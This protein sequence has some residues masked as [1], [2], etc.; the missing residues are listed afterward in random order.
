MILIHEFDDI[1]P[2]IDHTWVPDGPDQWFL[3]TYIDLLNNSYSGYWYCL[4][5]SIEDL[6]YHTGISQGLV[7]RGKIDFLIDNKKISIDQHK[8]FLLPPN[9][10]HSAV[11][12]PTEKGFLFF[13]TVVG[14]THYQ[15]T[16]EIIDANQYLQLVRQHYQK[17]KLP[18]EHLVNMPS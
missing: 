15:N 17:N 3:P 8:T 5:K 13:G 16:N 14:T 6:H 9:T 1:N 7:L 2:L 11:L 18:F 12:I 10:L 4:N